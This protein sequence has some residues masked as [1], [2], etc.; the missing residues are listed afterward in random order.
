MKAL[1]HQGNYSENSCCGPAASL[2]EF[3]GATVINSVLRE[4]F[5]PLVV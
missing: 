3:S 4:V 5:K 1:G 2:L